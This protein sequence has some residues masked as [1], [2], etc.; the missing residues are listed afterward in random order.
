VLRAGHDAADDLVAA[1][2][3]GVRIWAQAEAVT[4]R[5][6]DVGAAAVE[7]VDLDAVATLLGHPDTRAQWW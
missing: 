6:I 4:E 3:A 2:M 1:R 5:A 7:L